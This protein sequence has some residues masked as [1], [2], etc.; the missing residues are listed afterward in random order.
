MLEAKEPA[1]VLLVRDR[2]ADHAGDIAEGLWRKKDLRSRVALARFAPDDKRWKAE[3]AGVVRALLGENTLHQG[4]WVRGLRPVRAVLMPALSAV[5]RDKLAGERRR[6]ASLVLADYAADDADTLAELLL[7]AEPEQY[8]LLRFALERH[9]EKMLARMNAEVGKLPDY[10]KD[11]PLPWPAA[12]AAL[13]KEIGA[14]QGLVAERFAL[15][16]ALP[17]GRVAA[18]TEGLR[19]AGYRPIR[20]RPHEGGV[21]VVWTRDGRGWKLRLG[22][23]AAQAEKATEKG[24]VPADVAAYHT[25]DGDR[26]AVLFAE[27]EKGEQAVADAGHSSAGFQERHAV[28]RDAA[29]SPATVQALLGTDGVVRYCGVW[30]KWPGQPREWYVAWNDH[31]ITHDDKCFAGQRLLLDVSASAF[32]PSMAA[33]P[34]RSLEGPGALG[35]KAVLDGSWAAVEEGLTGPQ[36]PEAFVEVARARVLAARLTAVRQMGLLLGRCPFTPGIVEKHLTAAEELLQGAIDRGATEAPSWASDEGFAI[37]KGR[38]AFTRMTAP[39]PAGA[40]LRYASTWAWRADRE[41]TALHGLK[42]EDH[43]RRCAELAGQGWRPAGISLAGGLAASVWH[44]PRLTV[45]QIESVSR[46]EAVAAITLLRLG[47]DAKVWPLLKHREDPTVPSYLVALAGPLGGDVKM[48]LRRLDEEKDDGA[49]RNLILALGEYTDKELPSAMRGPVVKKL[50]GWYRDDP[51]PGVHAAVR[52]LLGHGMEGQAPRRLDWGQG[53]QLAR[54]DRELAA[55]WRE[56]A[57][58]L[59]RGW[60]VNGRGQTYV[61]F[62]RPSEFRMGSPPWEKERHDDRDEKPHRRVIRHGFAL[63]SALVTVREWEAF[64]KEN[65]DVPIYLTRYAPD[66]DCP[67]IAVSMYSAMRYCNWLSKK[68][69]IAPKEWCYPDKIAEGMK[70]PADLLKR[71]GYRLPLEAEWEFAARAGTLSSRS[72]GEGEELLKRHAWYRGNAGDRTWPV[73]MKRPNPW[74]LADLPGNAYTWCHDPAF[75]LPARTHQPTY[76]NILTIDERVS[77]T[78]RGASLG[79]AAPSVRSASRDSGRPEHRYDTDGLRPCRTLP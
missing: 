11:A 29:F 76:V 56:K 5:F 44:R 12:D 58:L 72:F 27:P 51:S 57:V 41:A 67:I 77:R 17:L 46:R 6:T 70:L 16:Q 66:P 20:V 19:A 24:L 7:D 42:P 49:R 4:V 79:S 68:E 74:G 73:G 21:A 78:L 64:R 30:R 60:Y 8:A 62:P 39:Q 59:K 31:F 45:P 55:G 43:L 32:V 63:A 37:L 22:L 48:L 15:C 52:W 18:V 14:A 69:G 2:L 71:R 3:A 35:W 26:H 25:K 1:E 28:R 53:K 61:V 75:L 23:T 9:R 33:Q 34:L 36:A 10:W 47:Q 38:P 40:K 50:L 13:V 54:I 65:P